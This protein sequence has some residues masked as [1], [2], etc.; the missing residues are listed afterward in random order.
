MM[1]KCC[2]NAKIFFF[3]LNLHISL[4]VSFHSPLVVYADTGLYGIDPSAGF[5]LNYGWRNT[6][7]R[8]ISGL[9]KFMRKLQNLA[10]QFTLFTG[11]LQNPAENPASYNE[12]TPKLGHSPQ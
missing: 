9:A 4:Q 12:F 2:T 3:R 11:K 1:R 5:F 8:L 7:F 6:F 10:E